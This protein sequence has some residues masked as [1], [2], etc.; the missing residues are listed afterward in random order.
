MEAVTAGLV[1]RS[2]AHDGRL[3]HLVAEQ[4][5]YPV[6]RTHELG[7]VGTPAHALGNR[8]RGQCGVNDAGQQIGGRLARDVLY[9]AQ[10]QTTLVDLVQADTA[11]AGKAFG[12][13]GR[14]AVGV[15]CSTV[16]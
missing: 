13:F 12:G 11:L 6:H 15:P 9:E 8:Q 5:Y 2:Q 3:D 10:L 7:T 1:A 16:R 4:H 14:V